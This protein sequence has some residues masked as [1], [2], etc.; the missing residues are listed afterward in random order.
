MIGAPLFICLSMVI[1]VDI[2]PASRVWDAPS[3]NT[4]LFGLMV[5]VVVAGIQP[6][7]DAFKV[8]V[9]PVKSL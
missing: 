9:P 3:V 8:G 7:Y 4:N 1:F 5:N 2:T 6:V